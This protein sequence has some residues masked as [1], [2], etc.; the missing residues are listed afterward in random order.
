MRIIFIRH[1]PTANNLSDVFL[2]RLD[3]DCDTNYIKDINFN[4]IQCSI[5][6]VS[7]VYCSPLKRAIQ[8]ANLVFPNQDKIVDNR[9]IERDLGDWSNVSKEKLRKECPN[10]FYQNGKLKFSY[11]PNGGEP[12]EQ[13]IIRVANFLLDVMKNHSSETVAVVTHNGVITTVKCILKK[14]FCDTEAVSFQP[15][16]EPFA[17]DF[18]SSDVRYLKKIASGD[19]KIS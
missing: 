19:F 14:D 12:F 9:L 10:G 15:Y 1:L 2:G 13:L 7:A 11:T 4:D 16:I 6:K 5:G 18:C 17:V 8:S 3:L